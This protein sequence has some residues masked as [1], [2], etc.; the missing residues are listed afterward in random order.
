M[1]ISALANGDYSSVANWQNAAGH[2]LVLND[3]GC[4]IAMSRMEHR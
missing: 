1:D 4:L 2:Q 3:K